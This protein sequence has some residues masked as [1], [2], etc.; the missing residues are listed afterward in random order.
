MKRT[1]H[2]KM[3]FWEL[4]VP[5]RAPVRGIWRYATFAEAWGHLWRTGYPPGLPTEIKMAI[6]T[7]E[8]SQLGI[9]YLT[10][11]DDSVHDVFDATNDLLAAG[12]LPA[13]LAFPVGLPI[14]PASSK[15]LMPDSE[16]FES[17]AVAV[18]EHVPDV[19]SEAGRATVSPE[20]HTSPWI[21]RE[22]AVG[23]VLVV[24][25]LLLIVFWSFSQRGP[26]VPKPAEQ[27][28]VALPSAVDSTSLNAHTTTRKIAEAVPPPVSGA[29]K[30]HASIQTND[31]SWITA[32]ADGKMLFSKLFTAGS[33]DNV[34]FI[35]RAVVR[36]GDA[37]PVEI[38]I[39]GK[40][41]G[42]LGRT[43]QVRVIVLTP[44]SSHFQVSGEPD[45]CTLTR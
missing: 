18:T 16:E 37:G 17:N 25:I 12:E 24:A 38:T 22:I 4:S 11:V 44:G 7:T 26:A 42:P 8:P 45:D 28:S 10:D 39:D 35:K 30:S 33:K 19:V 40:P 32:C 21:P 34:D 5:L 9:D 13:P 20:D 15:L 2:K 23:L 27:H 41:L 29:D 36:I 1:L 43:G 31:R 6:R 14:V 3:G